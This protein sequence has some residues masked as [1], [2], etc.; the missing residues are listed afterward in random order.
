[1]VHSKSWQIHLAVASQIFLLTYLQVIE[2]V[3]MFPWNDIRRGNGQETLD[4]AIGIAMTGFIVATSLRWRP[5]IWVSLLFYAAW[6]VLQIQTFWLPYIFGASERW[7][8]IHAANFAKT[9]QWLPREG[10]HL[11][12]DASHFVLQILLVATLV[13]VARLAWSRA[14]SPSRSNPITG[15]EKNGNENQ[16]F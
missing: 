12:P 10:N 11:P 2:W 9:I 13:A 5:G 8:K 4:I 15:K 3:E 16:V 7:A 14:V 6:L 1:M